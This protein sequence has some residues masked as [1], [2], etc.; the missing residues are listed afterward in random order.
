MTTHEER[1]MLNRTR[2]RKER[3]LSGALALPLQ[4]GRP[5]HQL[6]ELALHLIAEVEGDTRANGVEPVVQGQLGSVLQVDFL[7]G[8]MLGGLGVEN[9]AVEVEDQGANGSLRDP[10]TREIP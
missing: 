1:S 9:Q 10:T 2:M 3:A 6:A 5:I 7:A 8:L 4:Y